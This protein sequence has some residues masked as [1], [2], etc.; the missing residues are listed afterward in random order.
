MA[1]WP[2][3]ERCVTLQRRS[4]RSGRVLV[5]GGGSGAGVGGRASASRAVRRRGHRH[6]L[7]SRPELGGTE[8]DGPPGSRSRHGAPRRADR[9]GRRR[10]PPRTD[11]RRQDAES[12]PRRRRTP[13]AASASRSSRHRRTV[14][15]VLVGGRCWRSTPVAGLPH[16]DD[17]RLP[18]ARRPVGQPRPAPVPIGDADGARGIPA[19]TR[20]A[21]A[22]ASGGARLRVR[23]RPTQA[24]QAGTCLPPPET[25]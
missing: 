20:P 13:R 21:T 16:R 7:R 12:E 15:L 14:T 11:Y 2:Q 25:T 10:G 17:D 9:T 4:A 3:P 24:V 19:D 5:S 23:R 8:D 6:P 1:R 22:R 18:R